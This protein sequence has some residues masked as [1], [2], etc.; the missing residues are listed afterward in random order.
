MQTHISA[1]EDINRAGRGVYS[2]GLR[3]D[4]QDARDGLFKALRNIPGKETYLALRELLTIMQMH[5]LAPGCCAW[6]A[7]VPRRTA[8]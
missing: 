3:D 5:H 1:E 7:N 2:P 6:R 8:T 4:A